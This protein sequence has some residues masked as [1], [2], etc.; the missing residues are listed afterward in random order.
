MVPAGDPTEQ[1]VNELAALMAEG[2]VIVD[3]GNSNFGDS[4]R[5][6]AALAEQGIGFVDAGT[7]GGVWGLDNGY[8]LMVGG[9]DAD[10]AR[11]HPSSSHWPRR[12]GSPTSARSAPATTRRWSTTASSTG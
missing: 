12:T 8:A 10:V 1:T 4:V 6:G 5:R 7:S 9:A 2:D 3:G 11:P